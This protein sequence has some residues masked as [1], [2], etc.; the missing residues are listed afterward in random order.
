MTVTGP[1]PERV[2]PLVWSGGVL[3]LLD[4]RRLPDVEVWL[5]CRT[6]DDVARAVRS[7]AVRGAPAIGIAGGFGVALAAAG[8][9]AGTVGALLRD[10]EPGP[11]TSREPGPQR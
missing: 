7:L 11:R 8:S 9:E 10:V 3:R 6:A 4:Q 5:E 1:L 2:R